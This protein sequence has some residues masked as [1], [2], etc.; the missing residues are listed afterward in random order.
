MSLFTFFGSTLSMIFNVSFL[1]ENNIIIEE[2]L[3]NFFNLEVSFI[4]DI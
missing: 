2:K 1:S 4:K 3:I